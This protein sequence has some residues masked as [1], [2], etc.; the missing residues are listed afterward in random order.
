MLQVGR[1]L[2]LGQEPLGADHGGELGAEHLERD[3][4]VVAEVLGQVDG[5]HAAGA[6]LALE[7]V[8]VGE[9]G[10][11]AAEQFGHGGFVVGDAGRCVGAGVWLGRRMLLLASASLREYARDHPPRRRASGMSQ[12]H[13]ALSD[14]LADRYR[15]ERELGRGGMATVYLAQRPQA[16]PPGR[17]QGAPPRARRRARPRALPARDP[18]RRPA[19]ASPHPD[20]ARLGRGRRAGSGSPCR[21]SRASRSATGSGASASC[22]WTTRSASRARS[23]GAL[24]YAHQH[25]V[26]HRDIKPENIL[27]TG[28]GN[29]LVADFG[30]ARALR[31]RRRRAADRDRAS[32][33]ARRPT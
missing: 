26:I 1:G 27:L 3:L 18:A 10:L 8:A 12:L 17:A 11:E 15:I 9:G 30:I 25:G 16:R 24:D 13:D 5:G 33:S 31:R 2:D 29:T 32:R 20:R 28:D 6:E 23:A 14:A 19:P 22:R 21:S 4:A 7:A